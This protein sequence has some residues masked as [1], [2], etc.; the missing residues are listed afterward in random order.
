VITDG[1]VADALALVRLLLNERDYGAQLATVDALGVLTSVRAIPGW[2]FLPDD[3]SLAEPP[4]TLPPRP[5]TVRS[6]TSTRSISPWPTSTP[7]APTLDRALQTYLTGPLRDRVL[8][9]PGE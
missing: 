3:S 4:S 9:V 6:L 7:W 8:L 1:M 5:G 2:A